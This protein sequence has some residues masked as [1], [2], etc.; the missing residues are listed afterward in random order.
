[1]FAACGTDTFT[2]QIDFWKAAEVAAFGTL[3]KCHLLI[4]LGQ[5]S[6]DLTAAIIFKQKGPKAFALS[7]YVNL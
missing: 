6:S 5:K 1:M 4:V 7:P 3:H 2:S